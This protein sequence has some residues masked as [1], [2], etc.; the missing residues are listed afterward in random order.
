MHA[1]LPQVP[2]NNGPI[3]P[4][5]E[6]VTVTYAGYPYDVMSYMGG[7]VQSSWLSIVGADY[8]VGL[9]DLA[10]SIVLDGGPATI[11]DSEIETLL[12]QLIQDGGVPMPDS[13]TV[14]VTAFPQSTV[15]SRSTGGTSCVDF[16]GYHARFMLNGMWVPYCVIATCAPYPG[17]V[18]TVEDQL[19]RALSHEFIEAATDPVRTSTIAGY[20]ILDPNDPWTYSAG[21]VA[22]LCE[23]SPLYQA[24]DGGFVAQR[25]WSNSA[26]A[27]G[28]VSPCVPAPAGDVYFNVGIEPHTNVIVDAGSKAQT[29][30]F[31]LTG[32]STA[33]RADWGVY[34]YE[35]AGTIN[36][37]ILDPRING[38]P[39]LDPINLNNGQTAT[40]TVVIPADTPSGGYAAIAVTSYDTTFPNDVFGS[41]SIALVQVQ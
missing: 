16:G 38:G 13:N 36:P 31:A 28:T 29:V 18:L 27:L 5:P 41:F 1:A 24:P 19:D 15:I 32:W 9:G 22:D 26:A 14:Y 30:S 37:T 35:L 21:E 25:V 33:A 7:L 3:L 23:L 8:G 4:A 11:T 34:A 12:A 17:S 40:L 10:G 39:G 2:A 20:H 6:V